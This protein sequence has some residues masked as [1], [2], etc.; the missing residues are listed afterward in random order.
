MKA[1]QR[2]Y[3]PFFF[4]FFTVSAV[5]GQSVPA[6]EI[7]VC[8]S[9]SCT[10]HVYGNPVNAEILHG[11]TFQQVNHFFGNLFSTVN[12]PPRWECGTWSGFHGWFYILSDVGIWA[13]YFAIPLVL[14]FFLRKKKQEL[15][16]TG[17][18]LLFMAFI[19]SCGLTHLIDAVIFWEPIYNFSA[20]MRFITAVVSISTVFSLV[21]IAPEVMK[22]K[23]PAKL[24][25]IINEK[26]KELEIA[27]KELAAANME[28]SVMNNVLNEINQELAL[29]IREKE[30]VRQELDLVLESIPQIAWSTDSE[31]K[32]IYVNR[33]WREYTGLLK[34]DFKQDWWRFL[35]SDDAEK[36][37][38]NWKESLGCGKEFVA[39]GRLKSKNDSYEWFLIKGVPVMDVE[40]KVQ[41][42]IGTFTNIHQ[43]KINEQRK[44]TFLN[45]ASHELKTPLS[46]I[47]AYTE[48][49]QNHEITQKDVDL[50]LYVSKVASHAGKLNKL[51]NELL[52]VSHIDAGQMYLDLQKE[53]FDDIVADALH[54]FKNINKS[55]REIKCQ[56]KTGTMAIC[57]HAKIQQVV[58]NILNNA[59]KYSPENTVIS[60]SLDKNEKYLLCHIEDQ[61]S[62]IK[63]EELDLIFNPFYRSGNKVTGGLGL[64]LYISLEIIK[65]HNGFIH[66]RSEI[67]KGS[68]FTIGLPYD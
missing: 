27:N 5:F 62:G 18:F 65:K 25:E 47:S 14:A 64:G 11:S 10:I 61:G 15:P 7:S 16:F 2:G 49:I 13:A 34:D 31:G 53:N 3:I 29:Q 43:Q 52:D 38:D 60:V 37:R 39:E 1:L 4:L 6:N 24:Q 8:G 35:H 56:G 59:H 32:I 44:N 21:Q 66:V 36:I 63:G 50:S 22:F 54:D 57:D 45:I 33:Q 40:K 20:L 55:S 26:T 58:Y 30:I 51:I 42:W 41:K 12:W 28:L 17:V 23:S 68:I 48:F 19:F 67:D 9:E 46:I